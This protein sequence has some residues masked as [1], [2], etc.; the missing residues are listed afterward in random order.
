MRKTELGQAMIE[1]L[2]EV[3]KP[4]EFWIEGNQ[5]MLG[6][7]AASTTPF[8]PTSACECI[9][10]IEK[11]AYDDLAEMYAT[12]LEAYTAKSKSADKLADHLELAIAGIRGAKVD[13]KFLDNRL[14]DFRGEK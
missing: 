7:H 14:K 3:S 5:I 4:R 10:V 12:M 8:N 11:S 9:H 1:G 6:V 2:K 13:V